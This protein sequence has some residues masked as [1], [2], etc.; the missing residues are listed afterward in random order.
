MHS[1]LPNRD[2]NNSADDEFGFIYDEPSLKKAK[3][4]RKNIIRRK[5]LADKIRDEQ[6]ATLR[7]KALWKK[8]PVFAKWWKRNIDTKPDDHRY[9]PSKF[10][11]VYGSK[12]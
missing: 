2:T 5:V 9:Y 10:R 4:T 12:D 11:G 3:P 1:R 6:W 7:L 8:K